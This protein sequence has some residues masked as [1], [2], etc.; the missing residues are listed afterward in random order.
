MH[1]CICYTELFFAPTASIGLY[2]FCILMTVNAF[3]G[4]IIKTCLCSIHVHSECQL[5]FQQQQQQP[6]DLLYAPCPK[7]INDNL[8]ECQ[9][10]GARQPGGPGSREKSRQSVRG[11]LGGRGSSEC[12]GICLLASAVL[13]L[14]VIKYICTYAYW[15]DPASAQLVWHMAVPMNNQGRMWAQIPRFTEL[16]TR[17]QL[18]GGQVGSRTVLSL[19]DTQHPGCDLNHLGPDHARTWAAWHVARLV[20]DDWRISQ[21]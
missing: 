7:V 6:S 12:G 15:F 16:E 11:C 10:R 2:I 5:I 20:P 14:V 4:H 8:C 21:M 19:V 17:Q 3:I 1:W 13:S 18:Q 9:C